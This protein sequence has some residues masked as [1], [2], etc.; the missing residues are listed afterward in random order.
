MCEGGK[1]EK[2]GEGSTH[3]DTNNHKEE[4]FPVSSKPR[5]VSAASRLSYFGKSIYIH[6][7]PDR[8]GL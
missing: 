2:V 4:L 3:M 7:V 5:L 8:Y 6:A 1:N